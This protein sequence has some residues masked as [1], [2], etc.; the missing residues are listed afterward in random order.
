MND[1]NLIT[2]VENVAEAIN[3][4]GLALTL[5]L[6]AVVCSVIALNI[7]LKRS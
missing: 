4:L 3:R 1:P 6:C 2:A 5:S 7:A